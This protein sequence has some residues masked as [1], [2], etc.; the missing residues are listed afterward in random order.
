MDK[1]VIIRPRKNSRKFYKNATQFQR[2]TGPDGQDTGETKNAGAFKG[3]KIPNTKQYFRPAYSQ[4]ANKWMVGPDLENNL[5]HLNK[6]VKSCRLSYINGPNKGHFIETADIYNA[7]DPFFN[8]PEL[9]VVANEG[10]LRLN[11]SNPFHELIINSLKT[12]HEFAAPG[13]EGLLSTRVKYVIS[14]KETDVRLKKKVRE[15]KQ[16]AM[17]YFKN[18]NYKKKLIIATAMGLGV[19]DDIDPDFLDDILFQRVEDSTSK[20]DGNQTPQQLF[21]QLCEIDT[22]VLNLKYLI[23]KARRKGLLRKTK[24]EGWVLFGNPIARTTVELENYFKDPINAEVV[25]Q[26]EDALKIKE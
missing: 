2:V 13:E 7:R 12:Q 22:E 10:E 3:E 23:G 17:E 26:V 8:H 14:D 15:D 1:S 11:K 19:S 25:E 4:S 9:V 21:I 18:L 5:E 24:A 16:V 6:I 20:I